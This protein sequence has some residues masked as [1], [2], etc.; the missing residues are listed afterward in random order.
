MGEIEINSTTCG[1]GVCTQVCT[2][3][4]KE[5]ALTQKQSVYRVRVPG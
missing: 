3:T 2:H 1:T 4:W 5:V